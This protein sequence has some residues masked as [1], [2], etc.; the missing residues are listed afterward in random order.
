VSVSASV[1]VSVS[2]S[3]NRPGLLSLD[4]RRR[5]G[6]HWSREHRLEAYATLRRWAAFSTFFRVVYKDQLKPC[7]I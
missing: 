1:S 5:S 4:I 7:A 2:A 3:V 6:G